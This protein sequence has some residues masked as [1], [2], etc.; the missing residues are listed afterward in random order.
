MLEILCNSC[1][2]IQPKWHLWKII[3][4]K[5]SFEN[6]P[7]Q[8]NTKSLKQ[9][10]PGAGDSSKVVLKQREL[11]F[12]GG[13]GGGQLSAKKKVL[14]KQSGNYNMVDHKGKEVQV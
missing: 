13:G 1:T 2:K 10:G 6:C 7:E 12:F 9:N 8:H 3:V 4:I 5:G 14:E 11:I